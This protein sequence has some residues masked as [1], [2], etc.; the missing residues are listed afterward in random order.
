MAAS[1]AWLLDV[2]DALD[3]EQAHIV[4]ASY[5]GWLTLNL[6]IAAPERVKQ[7]ALLAPAGGLRPLGW[8]FFA[9]MGPVA[10]F[11]K[12]RFIRFMTQPMAAKGFVWNEPLLDQIRAGLRYRRMS[13]MFDFALPVVFSDDELRQL[14]VPVLLLLGDQEII[15]NPHKALNR[16]KRLFPHLD[17]EIIPGVGHGL[18]QEQP[19]YVNSRILDFLTT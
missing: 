15:C 14:N 7:I 5:G 2:M 12:K 1:A 19:A 8:K 9:T 16:A 6:A 17:A 10:L 13:K 11:P 3:I 18:S 4:G